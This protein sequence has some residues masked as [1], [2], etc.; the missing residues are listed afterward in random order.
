MYIHIYIYIYIYIERDGFPLAYNNRFLWLIIKARRCVQPFLIG[1]L[2]DCTPHSRCTQTLV[3]ADRWK[4]GEP[5]GEAYGCN[6]VFRRLVVSLASCA[7]LLT[8]S[9]ARTWR[10]ELAAVLL[11]IYIYIYISGWT[12]PAEPLRVKNTQL[13]TVLLFLF[14]MILNGLYHVWYGYSL[15]APQPL[16]YNQSY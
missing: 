3:G 15:K 5:V 16:A 13:S 10:S 6:F 4:K 1:C 9:R 2:F 12:H 11:Y 14:W 7:R 8:C